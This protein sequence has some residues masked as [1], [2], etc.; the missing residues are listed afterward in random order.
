M[1][2]RQASQTAPVS[3]QDQSCRLAIDESEKM[4]TRRQQ[5]SD[6]SGYTLTPHSSNTQQRSPCIPSGSL[7]SANMRSILARLPRRLPLAPAA[8][9]AL[10]MLGVVAFAR[11]FLTLPFDAPPITSASCARKSVV[12]LQSTRQGECVARPGG[13]AAGGLRRKPSLPLWR[14]I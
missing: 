10:R 13:S 12:C 1:D 3:P 14:R 2:R 7:N 5:Y 8:R 9:V 4:H 11:V 6:K